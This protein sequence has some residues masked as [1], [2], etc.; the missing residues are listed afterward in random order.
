MR[1]VLPILLA[2]CISLSR[3]SSV[4]AA[5]MTAQSDQSHPKETPHQIIDAL[6]QRIYAIGETTVSIADAVEAEKVASQE[7]RAYSAGAATDGLIETNS[8]GQ[9]PLMSAAYDGFPQVVTALLASAVVRQHIDD[10]DVLGGSAWIY[11]DL[12]LRESLAACNPAVLNNV[13]AFEPLMVTQ[14]YY[15]KARDNPYQAVRRALLSNGARG[16]SEQAKR[17]WVDHCK[18]EDA[19]T[20]EA[21]ERSSDVLNAATALGTEQLEQFF[22]QLQQKKRQDQG[23]SGR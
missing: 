21:I 19:R 16:D 3:P 18:N 14:F 10:H 15:L 6:V 7:I 11:A 20:K 22:I 5:Q 9:T 17:F 2:L 23:S 12:G 13:F 1:A 8:G 4:C